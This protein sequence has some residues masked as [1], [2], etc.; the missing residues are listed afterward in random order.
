M[1]YDN[2]G[3]LLTGLFKD[4]IVLNAIFAVYVIR[5]LL[6]AQNFILVGFLADVVLDAFEMIDLT[7]FVRVVDSVTIWK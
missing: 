2:L 6:V 7:T 5:S 1:L 4:G 3:I